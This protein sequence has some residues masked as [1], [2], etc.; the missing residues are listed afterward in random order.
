MNRYIIRHCAELNGLTPSEAA[1]IYA[2]SKGMK[3][4]DI[5]GQKNVNIKTI[6]IQKRSAFRKMGVNSDVE[7]I[8]YIYSLL[9]GLQDRE[10]SD[11]LLPVAF[12]DGNPGVQP[13]KN[14]VYSFPD[15][16]F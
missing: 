7:F 13:G 16:Y 3:L 14:C 15:G 12:N 11:G 9:P 8:H 5:A 4:K 2:V 10:A 1:V 6:S